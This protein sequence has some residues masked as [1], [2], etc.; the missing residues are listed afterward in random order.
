LPYGQQKRKHAKTSWEQSAHT[1][2]DQAAKLA[3]I[4]PDGLCKSLFCPGGSEAIE[5]EAPVITREERDQA[6]HILPTAIRNGEQGDI[7]I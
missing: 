3:Q 4:T 5:K 6:L 2:I 7:Y 1:D